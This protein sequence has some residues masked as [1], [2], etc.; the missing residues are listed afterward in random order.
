M[1]SDPLPAFPFSGL[2]SLVSFLPFVLSFVLPFFFLCRSFSIKPSGD[3][4]RVSCSTGSCPCW[5]DIRCKRRRT[6]LQLVSSSFPFF[7]L[8]FDLHR[9]IPLRFG[10]SF[11]TVSF[12]WCC[13]SILAY[14]HKRRIGLSS[15]KFPHVL[16]HPSTS[17]WPV[18]SGC[19]T[20]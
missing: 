15:N 13:F 7:F 10:S 2:N 20:R 3:R 8:F 16:D 17:S 9:R 14:L 18:S 5:K 12:A 4:C 6:R 1:S 11:L 19:G